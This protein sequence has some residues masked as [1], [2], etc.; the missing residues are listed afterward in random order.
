[1]EW[2]RAKL[3]A[4]RKDNTGGV[5]QDETPRV[6]PNTFLSNLHNRSYTEENPNY[7][8]ALLI[9]SCQTEKDRSKPDPNMS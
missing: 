5:K 1:M 9:S 7:V 2:T 4:G 6:N 8:S 3:W